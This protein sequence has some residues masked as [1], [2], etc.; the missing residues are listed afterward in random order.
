MFSRF[1]ILSWPWL[2]IILK[3]YKNTSTCHLVKG[4][5]YSWPYLVLPEPPGRL[6]VQ[7]VPQLLHVS[8]HLLHSLLGQV[9]HLDGRLSGV[10]L[11]LK[12]FVVKLQLL[13]G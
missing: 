12:V 2:I 6:L 9:L 3:I 11:T 13:D 5:H 1:P 4:R 10:T 8:L 7:S